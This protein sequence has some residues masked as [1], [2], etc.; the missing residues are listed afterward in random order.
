MVVDGVGGEQCP[1]GDQSGVEVEGA[2]A[3]GDL[4]ELVQARLRHPPRRRTTTL[5]AEATGHVGIIGRLGWVAFYVYTYYSAVSVAIGYVPVALAESPD[6]LR[7]ETV[8]NRLS[9]QAR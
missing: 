2:D 6:R 4:F 3:D 5:P 1:P 9:G 8:G 7:D